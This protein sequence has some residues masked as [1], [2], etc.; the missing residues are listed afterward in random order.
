VRAKC[1]RLEKAARSDRRY[2]LNYSS[3]ERGSV[4]ASTKHTPPRAHPTVRGSW[5]TACC[6]DGDDIPVVDAQL[7]PRPGASRE[8]RASRPYRRDGA[9][10]RAACP[11]DP[12]LTISRNP[13]APRRSQ[14]DKRIGSRPE[15]ERPAEERRVARRAAPGRSRKPTTPKTPP[16]P[17]G[18]RTANGAGGGGQRGVVVVVVDWPRHQEYARRAGGRG[19]REGEEGVRRVACVFVNTA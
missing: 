9:D 1:R 4:A 8:R 11:T 13:P 10:R 18:C 12:S 17:R 7:R 2:G 14:P 15:A 6:H 19:G 16:A 5:C 3:G